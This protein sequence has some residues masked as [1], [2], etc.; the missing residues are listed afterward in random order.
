MEDIEFNVLIVDDQEETRK[1]VARLLQFEND[2]NVVGTARTGKD[3]I[4]QTIALDPDV[5]LMDINMPDMDGIEATERIQE[6]AP[7][8]QIVILSV[9]GDTNYMRRAML[10]G[11]RDF[12]TKPPKSDELVT[13]IRRAGAKAKAIRQE[14]QY[15]GRGTGGLSDLRGTTTSLSGL[16]KIVAVYSPK[17][18][19]G[20]TTVATNLA[21]ALHSS[22]TP[23]IIVDANLQFGDVVVFLNE[24]S[25]T[26]VVDLT[27]HADQIDPEL[28]KDVVIH[29]ELSGIDILAAPPHPEDAEKITGAQFVKILQFL[30]RMYSYVIVDVDSSLSDV[31]LDTLDG[32]DLL[33]MISSQD[34]PAIINTRMM[35]N[36]LINNLGINK[37]KIVLVMNRFD[38]QLSITPEKVGHNLGH[39][40]AAVLPEDKEVVVPAVNRGIPFILGEGKSK[41]IGKSLLELVGKIRERLS[42]LEE[43]SVSEN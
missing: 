42:K 29:H 38:K 30:A 18:G 14:G 39:K 5:V 40:V 31:T 15:I 3:A 10:A 26:S 1:N 21:V 41:D 16:G 22:E 27:P 25:R 34:I 37:Q 12:L 4:K 7:V 11:A 36:L 2:I 23:V 13:V 43:V 6:Q 35:L 8:S 33:V 24:R 19:V 17:G 28:V 32:S 9:Q 20:T